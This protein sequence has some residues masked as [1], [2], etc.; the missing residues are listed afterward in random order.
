MAETKTSAQLR[1]ELAAAEWNEYQSARKA[2]QE[3][4]IVL[5]TQK[6]A[7][8]Q[9]ELADA[10]KKLAEINAEIKSGVI[11]IVP[12]PGNGGVVVTPLPGKIGVKGA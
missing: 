9:A 4:R 2:K 6:I 1:Q 7:T 10:K 3:E 12:K 11:G 5:L 8:R